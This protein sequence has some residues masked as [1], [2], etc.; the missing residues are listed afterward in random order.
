MIMAQE[1]PYRAFTLIELLVV[2]A[3]I[4]LLI[5]ILLPS[6]SEAREQAK[7][8]KCQANLANQ[9]K[10]TH[11]YFSEYNDTFPFTAIFNSSWVGICSWQYGG[12][13]TDAYWQAQYLG[14]FYFTADKKPLNATIFAPSRTGANDEV[15]Q[16]RCPSDSSSHLRGTDLHNP[17]PNAV[18]GM[19]AY[20]DVGTSYHF[21]ILS[22]AGPAPYSYDDTQALTN[23]RWCDPLS[24]NEIGSNAGRLCQAI[25]RNGSKGFASRFLWYY[26]NQADWA[27]FNRWLA[28]GNHRKFNRHS[29]GYLDGH[30]KYIRM[31]TRSMAGPNWTII[32]PAWVRRA[33][34]PRPAPIW[35]VSL[36][37][38]ED[39]IG[40]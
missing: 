11:C 25:V 6:L 24:G 37:V 3:I 1:R 31:N 9:L 5:S 26:E 34:Q 20:D 29:V 38:N 13:K 15:P 35:Y 22:V 7:I 23:W 36:L 39:P 10:V 32:N 4:A 30:A 14:L 12:K 16:L 19:S 17:D 8:L 33:F 28:I 40:D 2:V 21:N 18:T 27:L